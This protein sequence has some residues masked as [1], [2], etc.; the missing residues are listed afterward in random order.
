MVCSFKADVDDDDVSVQCNK[1]AIIDPRNIMNLF[2]L[3]VTFSTPLPKVIE[4]QVRLYC[5]C[6][7]ECFFTVKGCSENCNLTNHAFLTI[8]C[9]KTM[10][11]NLPNKVC[12]FKL[13]GGQ[14]QVYLR[15]SKITCYYISFYYYVQIL[16][17]IIVRAYLSYH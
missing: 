12:S 1:I 17:I 15:L 6:G 16:Y 5:K 8:F 2:G 10:N 9:G 13:P 7:A 4:T 14:L 3:T 11:V